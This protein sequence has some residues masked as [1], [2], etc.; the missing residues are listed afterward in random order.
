MT[1][2]LFCHILLIRSES[3]SGGV[4]RWLESLFDM[5][6]ALGHWEGE[7][8][9]SVSPSALRGIGMTQEETVRQESLGVTLALP[10]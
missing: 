7:G 2:Y 6:E 8:G 5:C 10:I 1:S 3:E 4:A 9:E